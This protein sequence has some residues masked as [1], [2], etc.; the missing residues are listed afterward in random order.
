MDS[1]HKDPKVGPALSG[2]GKHSSAD[3]SLN[4]TGGGHSSSTPEQGDMGVSSR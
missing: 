3:D 4:F 1:A 2:T